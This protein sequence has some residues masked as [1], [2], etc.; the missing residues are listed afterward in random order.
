MGALS[1]AFVVAGIV[2]VLAFIIPV[3]SEELAGEIAF[4][5]ALAVVVVGAIAY[6]VALAAMGAV[7][8]SATESGSTLTVTRTDNYRTHKSS[9]RLAELSLTRSFPYKGSDGGTTVDDALTLTGAK[10]MTCVPG[11]LHDQDHQE[12]VIDA[13]GKPA[14]MV[15]DDSEV[16]LYEYAVSD[17]AAAKGALAAVVPASTS[18][19]DS[20]ATTSDDDPV[21][22]ALLKD[23]RFMYVKT[24]FD[25]LV[26][27]LRPE[28]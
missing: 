13:D 5:R 4:F 25:G 7:T 17:D 18:D 20:C 23:G 6:C 2:G 11:H 14:I 15:V 10:P 12:R 1:I 9:Q 24:S 16:R 22:D 8:L 21:T 26:Y 28:H 3:E 19:P 27:T